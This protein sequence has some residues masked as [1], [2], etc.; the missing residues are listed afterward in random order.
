M[1]YLAFCQKSHFVLV[2]DSMTPFAVYLGQPF[3][4]LASTQYDLS[5]FVMDWLAIPSLGFSW[6]DY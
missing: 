3:Y 5:C 4:C 6:V 1:S 2:Q